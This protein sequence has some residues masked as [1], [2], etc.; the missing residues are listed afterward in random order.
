[1][2]NIFKNSSTLLSLHQEKFTMKYAVPNG[3]LVQE[4]PY[5]I[6]ASVMFNECIWQILR[7]S[8]IHNDTEWLKQIIKYI[9][10][11]QVQ[12]KT[13]AEQVHISF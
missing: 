11:V 1:M 6:L 2:G 9:L 8:V 13:H 3:N 12:P 5:S 10:T 4:K 7:S